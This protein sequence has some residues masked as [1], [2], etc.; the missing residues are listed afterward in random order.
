MLIAEENRQ[1]NRFVSQGEIVLRGQRI[2]YRTVCED[3]F[4][5]G[6]YVQTE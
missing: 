1:K 6:A 5:I 4:I 2:P 3:N